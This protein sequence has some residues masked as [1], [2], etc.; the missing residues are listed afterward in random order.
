MLFRHIRLC[1]KSNCF[2]DPQHSLCILTIFYF[3]RSVVIFSFKNA[4]YI[5]L[6]INILPCCENKVYS[7]LRILLRKSSA[8][9]TDISMPVLLTTLLY[10]K[11]LNTAFLYLFFADL[12]LKPL[13]C[14]ASFA[15]VEFLYPLITIL[16]PTNPSMCT[17]PSNIVPPV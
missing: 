9:M 11:V 4:K 10:F 5:S 14:F 13:I 17:K 6:K 15:A 16:S 2:Q 1:H 3:L 7:K 12:L 8:F